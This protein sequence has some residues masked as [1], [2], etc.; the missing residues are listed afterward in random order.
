MPS[1]AG[2]RGAPPKTVPAPIYVTLLLERL[3]K[4]GTPNATDRRQLVRTPLAYLA[5]ILTDVTL[6]GGGSVVLRGDP[7]D[8]APAQSHRPI[9]GRAGVLRPCRP[10]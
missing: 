7:R 10:P 9:L 6:L 8:P 4:L 2:D 3:A 5:Q 1:A